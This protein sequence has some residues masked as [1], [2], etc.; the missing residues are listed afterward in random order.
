M[1]RDI[2]CTLGVF[3]LFNISFRIQRGYFIGYIYIFLQDFIHI[4]IVYLFSNKIYWLI[5]IYLP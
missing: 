1:L 5:S 4:F 3:F 2:F